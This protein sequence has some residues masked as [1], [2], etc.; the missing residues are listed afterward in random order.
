MSEN[1]VAVLKVATILYLRLHMSHDLYIF[2]KYEI[3]E[4]LLNCLYIDVFD[5]D[6]F[7]RYR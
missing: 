4:Y 1:I 7:F 5:F 2:I 6:S 3:E